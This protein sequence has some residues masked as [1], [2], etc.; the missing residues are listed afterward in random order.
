MKMGVLRRTLFAL[1][2]RPKALWL[3]LAA[4]N[5]LNVADFSL[6]LAVLGAGGGEANPVMRSL[7]AMSTRWAGVFKVVAVLAASLLVW[8]N[9]RYRKALIAGLCM[10]VVFTCLFIYHVFG[11]AFLS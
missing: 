7:F 11:L 4:V 10:L 8:Q 9:R 5:A 3:L 6:T 2:D 1:R